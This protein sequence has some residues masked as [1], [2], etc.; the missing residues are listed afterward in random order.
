VIP[1]GR[2]VG[3]L[4]N[5]SAGA[6]RGARDLTA[7][8]ATLRAAGLEATEITA[9]SAAR[10]G[11]ACAK[12]V[13]DGLDAL[14]AVGGD[15][16]VNLAVRAV[17]GTAT[18]LGIVPCGTG[19]DLA[20]SLGVPADPVAAAAAVARRVLAGDGTAVDAV[21]TTDGDGEFR[22]WWACVLA[23]GFDSAVNER[24]N[25][26]RW[27]RGPRRYDVAILAELARLRPRAYRVTLDGE[28]IDAPAVM[29]A[30]GNTDSYGGG[31]RICPAA[32][33]ADGLL[34]VTVVGPVSRTDV[35]R[36]KPRL[37]AGT[38]VEDPRVRT[39]RAAEVRLEAAGVPAYADGEPLA[40]LPLVLTCVPGALTVLAPGRRV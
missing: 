37:Y 2:R 23:S 17:A 26:M 24:A 30:V 4:V 18:A 33:P 35:V 1:G 11:T 34:D 40:P 15:G 13:A 9:P 7:V 39:Y 6:G 36:L 3:V 16:T 31:L 27:P 8:L 28:T 29:V 25:R 20:V 14:V 22:G 5:P 38:H 21:R 19:N 12:A 10:A 32:D